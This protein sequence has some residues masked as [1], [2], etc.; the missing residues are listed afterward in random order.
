MIKKLIHPTFMD[1]YFNLKKPIF[2]FKAEKHSHIYYKLTMEEL[3][4]FNTSSKNSTRF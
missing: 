4:F 2:I 1:M 3:T